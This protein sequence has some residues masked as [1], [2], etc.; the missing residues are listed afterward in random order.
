MRV[1]CRVVELTAN[2]VCSHYTRLSKT[3]HFVLYGERS[4]HVKKSCRACDCIPY[5]IFS[6][7]RIFPTH[8]VRIAILCFFMPVAC[9]TVSECREYIFCCVHIARA[10]LWNVVVLC[11]FFSLLLLLC[12]WLLLLSFAL[13]PSTTDLQNRRIVIVMDGNLWLLHAHAHTWPTPG[14]SSLQLLT[15]NGWLAGGSVWCERTL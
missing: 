2:P 10:M 12:C 3:K 8:F 4:S 6:F 13:L 9:T 5:Y 14:A 15:A 1:L 11:F 7:G